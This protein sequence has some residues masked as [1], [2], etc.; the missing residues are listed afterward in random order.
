MASNDYYVIVYRVLTYLYNQLKNGEPVDTTKLTAK[1]VGVPETYWK[2]ILETL[3]E[4]GYIRNAAI[5]VD[6]T[7]PHLASNIS[8]SPAGIAFLHEN[9]TISKVKNAVKGLTDLVGNIPGL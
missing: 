9:S 6:M 7:G 3:S 4:E 8:I 2:Y 1:W 5:E